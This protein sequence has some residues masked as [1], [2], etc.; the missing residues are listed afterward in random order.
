VRE[1]GCFTALAPIASC[2]RLKNEK[3]QDVFHR[4]GPI[5]NAAGAEGVGEEWLTSG[6]ICVRFLLIEF[7]NR[8]DLVPLVNL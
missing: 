5:P 3:A 4:I 7:P 8:F 1:E 6:C 2:F